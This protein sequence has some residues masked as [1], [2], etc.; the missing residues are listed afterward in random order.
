MLC[1]YKDI[2][3]D[4]NKTK[5]LNKLWEISE[6]LL[7]NKNI[8]IYNQSLMDL[9]A[10][11][12]KT[13]NPFCNLCP[14]SRRC[15]SRKKGNTHL[16]PYKKKKEK[17]CSKKL[18]WLLPYN[19]SSLVY[20]KKRPNRGVWGGLWS[21][22]EDQ[23]LEDIIKNNKKLMMVEE[24]LVKHSS[25][26]HSFSHFDLE[27]DLYL[28]KSKCCTKGDSWKKINQLN[29]LGMPSPVIKV[30]NKIRRNGKDGIL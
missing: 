21:F 5:T 10:S 19:D 11:V 4:T 22:L 7:P 24:T 18:F 26:K 28:I 1:R 29:N 16:I 2:R 14:I 30:L 13:K 27:V 23:S 12:C 25:I 15:E 3:E 6:E 17:R 8:A 9:G 20:L